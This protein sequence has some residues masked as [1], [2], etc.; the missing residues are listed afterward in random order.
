LPLKVV[1][2]VRHGQAEL[3]LTKTFS[4]DP[5]KYPLTKL[6]SSQARRI[7]KELKLFKKVDTLYSSPI[8]RARQTAK[9]VG[10]CLGLAP[11]TDDRITERDPGSINEKTVPEGNLQK[12]IQKNIATN[13]SSGF[14]SWDSLRKRV[15]DFMDS[16]PA[17]KVIVAVTHGYVIMS[18]LG[19]I[20]D[21]DENSLLGIHQPPASITILNLSSNEILAVSTPSI[22]KRLLDRVDSLIQ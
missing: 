4:N 2:F 7:G 11:I 21:A 19:Q 12:F 3:N 10:R 14:E 18:A 8:L 6:G 16:L 1:I 15:S 22:S 9:I 17:D 13:Y 5:N 20:L